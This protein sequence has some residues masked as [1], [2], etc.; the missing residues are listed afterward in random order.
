MVMDINHRD[1]I[2]IYHNVDMDGWTSAAIVFNYAYKNRY[3]VEFVGKHHESPVN[4]DRILSFYTPNIIIVSDYSLEPEDAKKIIDSD[5]K[6]FWFDHHISAIRK[7]VESGLINISE[8]DMTN[9]SM[10]HEI[11]NDNYW[12]KVSTGYSGCE[13]TYTA[14]NK[15]K[16][17][18]EFVRLVGRYDVWDQNDFNRSSSLQLATHLIE[19][20]KNPSSPFWDEAFSGNNLERLLESGEI[21]KKYKS[22]ENK[23][24]AKKHGFFL[25]WKGY[26]WLCINATGN[27]LIGDGVFDPEIHDGILLFSAFPSLDINSTITWK[28]SMYHHSTLPEEKKISNDFS[29]IAIEYGGG[30]HAG[31]CGFTCKKL[32]FFEQGV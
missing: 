16:E 19:D 1:V 20:V 26:N 9:K 7:Y 11:R 25:N 4:I 27:S 21:L 3:S 13:L 28:V 17:L 15:N 30:G 2:S 8:E 5:V 32:P 23:R 18:P 31:A 29:K 10:I 24:I 22:I 14:L 12:F 6:L